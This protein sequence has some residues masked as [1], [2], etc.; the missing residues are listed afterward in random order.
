MPVNQATI[1]SL[2][3]RPVPPELQCV[4]PQATADA[5][6]E[7]MQVV[8]LASQIQAPS[9]VSVP[10]TNNTGQQALTLAQSLQ[11]LIQE[12]QAKT[13]QRRV[14]AADTSVAAG[15]S[16]TAYTFSP[17]MPDT[18]YIIHVMFTTDVGHVT[19]PTWRLQATTKTTTSF[20]LI[21]DNV[22]AAALITVVV[23]EARTIQ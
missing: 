17:A 22:P 14:V 2:L 23:E 10:V 1:A 3:A 9:G 6:A 12:L 4:L 20:T 18:N 8:G 13:I 11:T 19:I 16:K 21:L 7:I 15:N 5:I